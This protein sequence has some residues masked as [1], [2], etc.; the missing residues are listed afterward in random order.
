MGD[1]CADAY[2][3]AGE[4]QI[5]LING[6]GI[7][8]GLAAGDVTFGNVLDIYPF[9][10]QLCVIEATG[11]QILDALEMAYRMTE[12][13]SESGGT[14]IGE[15][16]AFLQVSGIRIVLDPSIPTA[17]VIDANDMFVSCEG[18][19][20]VQS[21]EVLQED[22][23]YQSLEPEAV[24]RVATNTY[25]AD[26]GDGFSMLTDCSRLID[27]GMTDYEV[28]IHYISNELDGTIGTEY[29]YSQERIVIRN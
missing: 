18:S 6:G 28:L 3:S 25:L 2:R 23:S 27:E 14:A 11:Q 19:R 16:S 26:G 13:E 4:A 10:N 5:A 9:G 24:Y 17:V 15:S 1:F 20:R 7:R 29:E 21:V 12:L 8:A 22:G